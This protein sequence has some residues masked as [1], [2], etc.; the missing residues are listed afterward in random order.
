MFSY[1]LLIA[2]IIDHVGYRTDFEI[3]VAN[4]LKSASNPG[5][6]FNKNITSYNLLWISKV[7]RC[8]AIWTLERMLFNFTS[9]SSTISNGRWVLCYKTEPCYSRF[10]ENCCS[11]TRVRR[12][13]SVLMK[14]LTVSSLL[15]DVVVHDWMPVLRNKSACRFCQRFLNTFSKVEWTPHV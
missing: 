8:R 3:E 5:T 14:A 12:S 15:F 10:K 7:S 6:E 2:C 1:P 11:K 13:L 4:L 9:G